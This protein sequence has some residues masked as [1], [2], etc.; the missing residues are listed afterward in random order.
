M[1]IDFHDIS[2]IEGSASLILSMSPNSKFQIPQFPLS[3]P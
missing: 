1:T 3:R 2:D